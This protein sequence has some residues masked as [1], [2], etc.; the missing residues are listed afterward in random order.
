[1]VV[2]SLSSGKGGWKYEAPEVV[3][4]LFL[5]LFRLRMRIWKDGKFG[6]N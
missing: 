3:K 2:S 6:L 4:L 1:M 5:I